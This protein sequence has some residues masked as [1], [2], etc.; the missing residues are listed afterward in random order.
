M[1]LADISKLDQVEATLLELSRNKS[2]DMT[3][4]IMRV[5]LRTFPSVVEDAR[6]E[7]REERRGE[8]QSI[9]CFKCGTTI[10]EYEDAYCGVCYEEKDELAVPGPEPEE[11]E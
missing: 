2:Y 10:P 6:A 3:D 5:F 1:I 4:E 7:G 8:A 9:H 11:K